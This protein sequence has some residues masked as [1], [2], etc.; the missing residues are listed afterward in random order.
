MTRLAIVIG[1]SALVTT[2]GALA[3][4]GNA[5]PTSRTCSAYRASCDSKR[6]ADCEARQQ[7]C[8]KSGCW[9]EAAQRSGK[10]HCGLEKK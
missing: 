6:A 9:A 3:D 10:A 8:L 2:S 4:Q 5:A 1:L 7:A